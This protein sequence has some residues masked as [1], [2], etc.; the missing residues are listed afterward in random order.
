[1]RLVKPVLTATAYILLAVQ[2]LFAAGLL[3]AQHNDYRLLTIAGGSM[4][5]KYAVGDAVL[6]DVTNRENPQSGD[7]ITF[8]TSPGE[9]TTHRVVSQ[10]D[11]KGD[12]YL[13]TQGDANNAPDPDLVAA[14]NVVGQPTTHFPKGGYIAQFLLSP[15]GMLVTYGP[16]LALILVSQINSV[17]AS[18]AARRSEDLDDASERDA[19]ADQSESEMDAVAA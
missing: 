17:R 6:L 4:A 14:S 12:L 16:T 9:M 1:M 8:W 11:I 13:R 7:I 19:A 10:H 3:L 2:L 15:L 18:L 5:P